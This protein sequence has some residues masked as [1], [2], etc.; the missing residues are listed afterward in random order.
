MTAVHD[1]WDAYWAGRGFD[2]GYFREVARDYTT[3]LTR[4]L[5]IGPDAAVLDFGCGPGFTAPL[6]A[7]Q[8]ERLVLFDPSPAMT[9]LAR[10]NARALGNVEVADT[11]EQI[12]SK[13]FD[14]VL[15]NS[16]IQYFERSE[17]DDWLGRWARMLEPEGRI[18]I[19]DVLAAPPPFARELLDGLRFALARRS[20]AAFTRQTF[21]LLR[22]NYR[23]V[24]RGRPLTLLPLSD[25]ARLAEAHGLVVNVLPSNLT[26]NRQRYAVTLSKAGR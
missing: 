17:L 25:L 15:V 18:I 8:V 7:P 22:S 12:G 20:V 26:Y 24:L 21:K 11:A 23:R 19:S 13:R 1:G 14:W 2:V 10:T 16:V 9:E 4:A 6:L 5:P 3:R